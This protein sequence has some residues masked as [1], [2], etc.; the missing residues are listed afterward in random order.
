MRYFR[1]KTMGNIEQERD[2]AFLD[3]KPEDLDGWGFCMTLGDRIGSHYPDD[4]K[5]Y[6]QPQHPGVRLCDLVGNCFS[7]MIVTSR[8][9]DAIQEHSNVEIEY[10]PLSIFNHRRRLHSDD[11]WIINPIGTIDCLDLKRSKYRRGKETGEIVSVQE[12]VFLKSRL[13]TEPILLRVPQYPAHYF[14]NEPT[15][16][17]LYEMKCTNFMI[18]IVMCSED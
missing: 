5:V 14:L 7:Y 18:D 13:E 4:A 3:K 8:V 10:L 6:M 12:Y 16:R 2:Q 15:A 11:Y 17:K 1:I 9:K